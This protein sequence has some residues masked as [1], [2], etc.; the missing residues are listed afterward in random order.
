MKTMYIYKF[1]VTATRERFM[2]P[3]LHD[4]SEHYVAAD[5]Y[6]QAHGHVWAN[7]AHGGWKIDKIESKEIFIQDIRTQN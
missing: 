1:T 6:E 4:V 3:P 7:L 5:S 2:E